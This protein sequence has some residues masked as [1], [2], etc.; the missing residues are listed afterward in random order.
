M[1][2]NMYVNM[3][4]GVT[5]LAEVLRSKEDGYLDN[6]PA[7]RDSRKAQIVAMGYKLK[8]DHKGTAI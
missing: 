2:N 5:R 1:D 7:N 3:N 8:V 6:L 4:R